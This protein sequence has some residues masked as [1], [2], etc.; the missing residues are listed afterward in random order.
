MLKLLFLPFAVVFDV[1]L[2]AMEA[3]PPH[4]KYKNGKDFPKPRMMDA[5]KSRNG[6][7]CMEP[8]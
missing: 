6:T 8:H 7:G 3:M 1:G 4:K 5:I 2:A